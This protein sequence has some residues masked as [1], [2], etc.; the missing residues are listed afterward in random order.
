MLPAYD[1]LRDRLH[2]VISDKA[3]QGHAVEGL[4][5]ELDTLPDSYAALAELAGRLADLPLVPDWPYVEPS[6]LDDIWN[7]ADPKRPLGAIASVDMD[8]SAKRVEAAF[9]GSVCGC[10]LGKPLET[11][12]TGEEIHVGLE[13]L[14]EWPLSQYVSERI[15]GVL[16][17]VHR[18]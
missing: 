12:L 3:E 17:R 9:L 18:S 11:R 8:D 2:M 4:D 6:E 16:P 7:E 5:A 15:R 14:G 13:Q 1:L 10:V